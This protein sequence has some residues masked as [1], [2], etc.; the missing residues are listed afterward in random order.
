[1]RAALAIARKDTRQLTRYPLNLGSLIFLPLYQGLIP[2]LLFGAAFLVGGRAIGL[3]AATGSADLA[4]FLFLGAIV[5]G[6]T[7]STFWGIA[8]GLRFELDTGTLEAMWLTPTRRDTLVLGR[9]LSAGVVFLLTQTVLIVIGIGVFGAHFLPT[10]LFALP[11][12]MFAAVSMVG[13]AYLLS[14]VVLLLKEASFFIDTTNFLTNV[15]AG[16]GFPVTVLPGVAQAVS[17]LLPTTYAL[18]VLRHYAIGSRPLL[19]PLVEHLILAALAVL[20]FPLGRV[21]FA[22]ADRRLARTGGLSQY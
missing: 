13:V 5:T 19:D 9:A 22:R 11:A 16:V 21:V 15:F 10:A 7:A 17:F 1:M 18:D 20:V 3:E 4:G 2:S 8:F 14:S 6:L 12:L